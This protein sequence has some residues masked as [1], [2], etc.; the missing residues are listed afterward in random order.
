MLRL[1][2]LPAAVQDF[3][4]AFQRA[5]PRARLILSVL[6]IAAAAGLIWYVIH[7]LSQPAVHRR[8]PPPVIVAIA[9]QRDVTV[10][11]R[12]IG[13]VVANATVQ[14][15]SRVDGQLL[16]TAFREGQIVHRGDVLFQLDPRTYQAALDGA[17]ATLTSTRAKAQRYAR[18]LAEK[19]VAPQD[20]D[21]AK[22]AY[23]QAAAAVDAARL[24]LNYTRIYSPIEGKTGPI[25][26]QPGNL[27]KANDSNALVAI[28]QVQPVKVSFFLP[29]SDL[30]RVQD[31]MSAHALVATVDVHDA[32]QSHI[33]APVDFVGNAVDAK[34]GTIE[35][36]ATF[37]NADLRLVPGQVVDVSASIEKLNRAIVVPREAVNIGPDGRYVFTIDAKGDAQMRAVTVLYDDGKSDAVSGDIHAGDEVITQGQLRV[38]PGKPVAIMKPGKASR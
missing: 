35:L 28:T 33:S 14:V 18:L 17:V 9:Q 37:P 25:L 19:A 11:E 10:A 31:R 5:N 7:L 26:I 32:A 22:A 38:V 20:A 29:Q 1:L 2:T 3:P 16:S 15:T 4:A 6:A 34:T 36:R 23:L 12:T 21:D 8:P 24:N 13:T 30:P 27:V